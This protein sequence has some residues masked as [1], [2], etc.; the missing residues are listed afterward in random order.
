[1]VIHVVMLDTGHEKLGL[2]PAIIPICYKETT[3]KLIAEKGQKRQLAT[4]QWIYPYRYLL[5][6]NITC[7]NITYQHEAKQEVKR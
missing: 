6:K 1:M 4:L 7:A 3:M 5:I 2:P